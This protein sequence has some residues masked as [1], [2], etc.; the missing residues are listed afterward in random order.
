VRDYETE[1]EQRQMLLLVESAQRAGRSEAEI[2]E[3]VEE[4]RE[5]DAGLDRAA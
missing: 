4:A 5:A 3:L 2:A 1:A